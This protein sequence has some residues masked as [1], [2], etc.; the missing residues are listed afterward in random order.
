MISSGSSSPASMYCLGLA[1]ELGA[2]GHGLAQHVAGGDV[3]CAV[4]LGQQ[5]GLRA[6]AGT[7]TPE[8]HEA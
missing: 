3:G 8:E 5:G 4:V 6:L 1:T 7:L 2:L